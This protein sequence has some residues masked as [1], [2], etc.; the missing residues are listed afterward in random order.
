VYVSPR[1]KKRLW[2]AAAA[3][4]FLLPGWQ[5]R[6][7]PVPHE[8]ILLES[9]RHDADEVFGVSRPGEAPGERWNV[10][11]M[12]GGAA[13]LFDLLNLRGFATRVVPPRFAAHIPEGPED[14]PERA[15]GYFR[16]ETSLR[17]PWW[18]PGGG[19]DWRPPLR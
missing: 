16:I 3:A 8:E 10:Q 5:G 17:W 12:G 11:Y 4:L 9:A 14:L 18:F 13:K 1:W 2:I 6:L 15:D 7:V 19:V